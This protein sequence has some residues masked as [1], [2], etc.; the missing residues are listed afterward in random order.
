M[1]AVVRLRRSSG[2]DPRRWRR[3]SVGRVHL[4]ALRRPGAAARTWRTAATRRGSSSRL[5]P[6][7]FAVIVAELAD[8]ALDAKA[9]ALLGVLA[10]CGAALRLPGGVTGLRA[11][12][13]RL[14]P[15]GPRVR[16]RLRVRARRAHDVRV[17]V[18]HR[19]GRAVVAVPDVRCGVGRVLRRLSSAGSRSGGGVSSS[20]GTASW[21]GLVYGMLLNM[22]FW[23]YGTSAGSE[24]SF[25]PGAGLAENLRRF[26]AFHLATSL[27][28][29]LPRAAINA[30]L[31]LA[32]RCAGAGCA[33][34]AWRAVPRS[35]RPSTS[36]KPCELPVAGT[37]A[38]R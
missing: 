30:I 15:G 3:S 34:G 16:S 1:T 8:G 12:V 22:W 32:G 10:A 33:R 9:V 27:G 20:P 25:V 4:A 17:G 13:L 6:L 5:L 29:D 2:V 18:D 26:W 35:A 21:P 24:L 11:D 7:L 37:L 19:R 14:H 31:V 23:P 38:R 36:K 28:W